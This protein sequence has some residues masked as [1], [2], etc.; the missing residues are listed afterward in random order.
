MRIRAVFFD[1][2]DTIAQ[3]RAGELPAEVANSAYGLYIEAARSLGVDLDPASVAL[4]TE[5]AWADFQTPEGPVHVQGSSD[6]TAF[7]GV[8]IAVHRRRLAK[9][10]ITGALADDIGRRIDALEGDPSRYEVFEDVAP[11][12]DALG[13][14]GVRRI[15]VSNHV[16]H[17]DRIVAELGL[18]QSFE[19]IVNSARVG[20]RKPHPAIY[21]AALGQSG[22][23]ADQTVMVGDSLI[24]DVRGAER[25]GIHGVLLDRSGTHGTVEGV[26]VVRSLTEVPQ[27]WP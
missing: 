6:E 25:Q 27:Q 13:Q 24:H 4:P 11:V 3:F 12:L 26:R 22:V 19:A 10:G 20:Y 2:Q 15:I 17:L 18:A 23:P 7:Q 14:N 8:R 5:Q 16:W 1:F 9:A 21:R